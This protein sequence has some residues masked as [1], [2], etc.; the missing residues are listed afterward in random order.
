MSPITGKMGLPRWRDIRGRWLETESQV[1]LG[2]GEML[3]L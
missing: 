3:R 1:G 2:F